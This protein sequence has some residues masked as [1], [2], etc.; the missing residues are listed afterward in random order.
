MFIMHF[1]YES[2]PHKSQRICSREK[3]WS[4]LTADSARLVPRMWICP[5]DDKENGHCSG[6]EYDVLGIGEFW[7]ECPKCQFEVK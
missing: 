5:D 1:I 4:R 7:I 3:L 2:D 6:D